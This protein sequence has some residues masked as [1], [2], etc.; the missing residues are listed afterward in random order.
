MFEACAWISELTPRMFNMEW[1]TGNAFVDSAITFMYHWKKIN[2]DIVSFIPREPTG[3]SEECST[4]GS[5]CMILVNFAYKGSLI[6]TMF[7]E[8]NFSPP[9]NVSQYEVQRLLSCTVWPVYALWILLT[10]PLRLYLL[11]RTGTYKWSEYSF[12][13]CHEA[14]TTTVF[15]YDKHCL[16]DLCFK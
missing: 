8:F 4:S 14:W 15:I 7:V 1:Q 2:Y 6:I 12:S 3:R 13:K 10:V 16:S 9:S 5:P 11:Q